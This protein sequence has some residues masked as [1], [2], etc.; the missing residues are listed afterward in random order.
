MT[1]DEAI[2]M[3]SANSGGPV[4]SP[5]LLLP[6]LGACTAYTSSFQAHTILPN[7]ISAAIVAE[8]GARG[9]G[10]G[11]SLTLTNGAESRSIPQDGGT[12]GYY[13]EQLGNSDT[14]RRRPPF[15]EPGDLTLSGAG[16]P[17]V[18]PFS[19]KTR[20]AEPFEWIDREAISQVD[21]DR[22]LTMH[23]SGLAGDR[24]V[25]ILATN[26]DQITTAIGTT[27]CAAR[28]TAG[29][30]TIPAAMLA[31]LPASKDMAGVPYDQ[32]FVI[33]MPMKTVPVIQARGI[34]GGAIVSVYAIGRFVEYR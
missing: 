4:L 24:T 22:P 15:L 26:V 16:G 33:S 1:S 28:A 10:A 21:R 13:R 7:S 25:L 5:L 2:V 30:F 29:Q 32:L 3:F 19:L 31:N 14:R 27:L 9:L 34:D 6:P 8:I 17:D 18:G 20:T 11:S 12:Y 23:W